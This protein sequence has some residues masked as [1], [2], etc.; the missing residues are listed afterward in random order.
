M[1]PDELDIRINYFHD[2][3]DDYLEMMGADRSRFPSRDD[4]RE[5]YLNDFELPIDERAYFHLI[6]EHAGAIVGFSNVD[7]IVYGEEAFMHAHMLKAPER[8]HGLGVQCAKA[9]A[10]M[11]FR[12]L[13]LE[14][15]FAE[16]NALNTAPNRAL[17]RAGFHFVFTHHT[18]PGLFH[19]PQYVTRWTID[20]DEVDD[21]DQ[22][23][24]E[25]WEASR[26][27][28]GIFPTLRDDWDYAATPQDT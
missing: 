20:R 4:W 1:R 9:S 14:R 15:L 18:T 7:R 27:P 6:W 13:K 23:D 21:V 16:P 19:F 3:A 2:A 17:Q 25:S 5:K 26:R 24:A 28:S 8:G 22:A 12:Y 10:R 11:Y